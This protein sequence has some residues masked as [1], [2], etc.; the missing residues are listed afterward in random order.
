MVDYKTIGDTLTD[1]EYNTITTQLQNN[2]TTTIPL[3]FLTTTTDYFT[4]QYTTPHI[5]KRKHGA[6]MSSLKI[7]MKNPIVPQLSAKITLKLLTLNDDLLDND[8]DLTSTVTY[9]LIPNTDVTITEVD[10]TKIVSYDAELTIGYNT[11]TIQFYDHITTVTDKEVYRDNDDATITAQLITDKGTVMDNE[12]IELYTGDTKIDEETITD[13]KAT[14]TYSC[15]GAGRTLLTLKSKTDTSATGTVQ[16]NDSIIY[17]KG[18]STDYSTDY[19]NHS[20]RITVTRDT[21]GTLLKNTTSSSAFYFITSTTAT[22][23]DTSRQ[24]TAPYTYQCTLLEHSGDIYF[25]VYD[26]TTTGTVNYHPYNTRVNPGDVFTIDVQEDKV[27]IYQNNN[28][29]KSVTVSMGTSRCGIA[30]GKQTSVK[31]KESAI[32]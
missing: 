4:L 8:D 9:N 16:I 3:T 13:K 14:F 5:I 24:W 30:M 28:L 6:N 11:P 25:Q 32:W 20:S 27:E 15:T 10:E 19:Y 29:V 23:L 2:T 31:Y 26:G 22:S 17:D 12:D 21:E 1:K 18:T 7:Q